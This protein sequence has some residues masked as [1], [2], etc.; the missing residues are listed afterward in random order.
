MTR[1]GTTQ[2]KTAVATPDLAGAEPYEDGG[3]T[4]EATGMTTLEERQLSVTHWLLTAAEDRDRARKEWKTQGIALL[5][6]GATLSAVRIPAHLVWG[7]AR[8]EEL[9]EVDAFLR[10]FFDG[11]AMFMDIHAHHYY[12]LVPGTSEWRW[13]NRKVPGV[14][15]LRGR[16]YYL[17][18]P[19]IALT[20]P[21][22]RSYW[23]LPMDTAGDLCYLDEVE[24]LV[25]TGLAA[26]GEGVGR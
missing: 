4:L 12:A 21:K 24:S 22:G 14:E 5:T 13:T 19:H 6:C 20:E 26:R 10:R 11:G 8:T 9:E 17:G 23:S 15:R 3:D 2:E 16:T 7:A 25:I 18:V 1:T